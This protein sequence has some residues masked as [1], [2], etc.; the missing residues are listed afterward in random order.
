MNLVPNC[1]SLKI[2]RQPL[3]LLLLIPV[4]IGIGILT[5]EAIFFP[6]GSIPLRIWVG[7]GVAVCF[8]ALLIWWVVLRRAHHQQM[9]QQSRSEQIVR[10]AV[11]GIVTIDKWGRIQSLNPAAEKLFGYQSKEVE[12][13]V[14]TV[15]LIEPPSTEP[16]NV[17]SD[18]VPVGT[19]LGLA[20]GARELSG[21]N[22]SG[23]TF[24]IELGQSTI[25]CGEEILSVA[26][27]R[28]VSERK[29]A[30]RCLAAHYAAT[31]IL[32][33]TISVPDALPSIL[34]AVCSSLDLEAGTI[35][36]TDRVAREMRC[37][38]S[39]ED[40]AVRL[41]NLV[42]ALQEVSCKVGGGLPG[43][44]WM[45][46]RP[47]WVADMTTAVACVYQQRACEMG[48]RSALAIPILMGREVWGVMVFH[49]RVARR[50]DRQLLD[51]MKLLGSQLGHFVARKHGEEMLRKTTEEAEAANRAK[52]EFLANMSHEIRTPMNGVIGMTELA[53]DTELSAEQRGYLDDVKS[54]A[55][56]LL[57]VINDI[58]DFSKIEAGKLDLDPIEFDLRALLGT[59]LKPLGIKAMEKGLDLTCD[60]APEVPAALIGDPARLRQV[61]VNLVGNAL[62]FTEKGRIQ[63]TV[64]RAE[65]VGQSIRLHFS[66]K[67]TGIGVAT[68]KQKL[69][70]EAFSQADGSTTR[71]FGG[72]GLGL[73]IS[74]QL[75]EMMGGRIWIESEAGVGATFHF[76]TLLGV[77]K[78]TPL[79]IAIASPL[80]RRGET[81]SVANKGS[82]TG[83][84]ILLAEDNIVNQKVASRLLQKLGHTVDVANNGVEALASLQERDYDLVLMDVQMPDMGGLEATETIRASEKGTGRHIPIIAMTAHAMKGDRERCLNAGMDG[85]VAK[86]VDPRELR[87]AIETVVI[88]APAD[89]SADSALELTGA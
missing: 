1:G 55:T 54:S 23:E 75:I 2:S 87:K 5:A 44:V 53:L 18:S 50:P 29:K 6:D 4:V 8:T 48:L 78:S 17:L 84:N 63:V 22:K 7:V 69:I 61:V 59:T 74:K 35:W 11:D 21:R 10:R 27:I 76:T 38:A 73:T 51:I 14:I 71:K 25:L 16:R 42:S 70:F 47:V 83:L 49:A 33:E 28:D 36:K 85:Y 3:P 13:E 45:T 31:C 56:A 58:L 39:Y 12:G 20:A 86:P 80:E 82:A 72:T 66:V 24:P 62:K 88:A 41:P 67:D 89:E 40:A 65:Q 81:L 77:P 43:Q 19:I 64:V 30:Q 15:L 46:A 79:Q 68:K 52:S 26:F 32:A 9:S 60:V 37:V 34:R 57:K